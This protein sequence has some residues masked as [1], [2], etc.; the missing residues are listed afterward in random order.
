MNAVLSVDRGNAAVSKHKYNN[1]AY[2][3]KG[4]Y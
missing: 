4:Y 3:Y 2:I 1:F